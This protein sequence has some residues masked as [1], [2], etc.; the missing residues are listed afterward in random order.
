MRTRTTT[1]SLGAT[2]A[3]ALA[4]AT[5]VAADSYRFSVVA[6]NLDR[7]VGIAVDGSEMVYFTEV[8][9][10]GV[11]GGANGVSSLDLDTGVVTRLNSGEP[12]PTNLALDREGDLYWTCKSAGVI[13]RLA[14]GAVAPFDRA[15]S[16]SRTPST[17]PSTTRRA[18][19]FP[20]Y[21]CRRPGRPA[22]RS[23][24]RG[25]ARPPR[26]APAARRGCRQP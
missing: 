10:P 8:P 21:R 14:E 26:A 1:L 17:E 25:R 4:I 15:D 5:P 11:G 19:G 16:G 12:E 6:R 18:R 22:G 3:L 20:G 13:L 7:P 2:A 24:G 23:P 9:D